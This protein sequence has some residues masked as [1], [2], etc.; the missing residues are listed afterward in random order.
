MD[1]TFIDDDDERLFRISDTDDNIEVYWPDDDTFYLGTVLSI[2]DDQKYKIDY[3]DGD[4][5]TL[6]LSTEAW[7]FSSTEDGIVNIQ[8]AFTA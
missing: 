2:N 1:D 7:R 3:E 6:D 5:E 4:R 8:N